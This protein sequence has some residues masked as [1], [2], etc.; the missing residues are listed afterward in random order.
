MGLYVD[1]ADGSWKSITKTNSKV[2]ASNHPPRFPSKGT[3]KSN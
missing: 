1:K 3:G 2:D